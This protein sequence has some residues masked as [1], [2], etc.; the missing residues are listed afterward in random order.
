MFYNNG[1]PAT[2][3]PIYQQPQYQPYQQQ[4]MQ[5]QTQPVQQVQQVP[6]QQQT[7]YPMAQQSGFVRV[8][9]E[10]EAR[11]YPV[12]PGNSVTF[13]DE[14][15]PYCYT[16]TVNMG[17]LDRPVFEKFRLIKEDDTQAPVEAPQ[18]TVEAPQR[19]VEVPVMD[20]SKYATKDDIAAFRAELDTAKSDIETFRGDLYGLAGKKKTPAKKEAVT[21]E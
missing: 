15:G 1:F 8:R 18:R 21:D 4:V 17:Q 13:I 7:Q 9:N 14:T 3:Q 6:Q 19:P 11:M 2:Y 16:K 5:Q 20:L 12:A 10:N